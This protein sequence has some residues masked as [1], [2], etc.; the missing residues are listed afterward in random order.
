ME[1]ACCNA[2]YNIYILEKN[3]K[4]KIILHFTP[5]GQNLPQKYRNV[6]LLK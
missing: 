1:G 5:L 2:E 3:K 6:Q 4:G